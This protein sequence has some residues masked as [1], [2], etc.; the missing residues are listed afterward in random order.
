MS[1]SDYTDYTGTETDYTETTE[2]QDQTPDAPAEEP[3]TTGEE[4]DHAEKTNEEEEDVKPPPE[5]EV[6]PLEGL[7]YEDDP[8]AE[9]PPYGSMEYWEERYTADPEP[10]EWYQTPEVLLPHIHDLCDPEASMLI[11]GNGT[12]DLP[13]DIANEGFNAITV[14]DFSKTAIKK[15]RR[16]FK[17]VE[18]ITWKVGDVRELKYPAGEFQSV[19]DKGTLDC[20]FQLG[21][22][23]V[24][25]AM[26]EISRVLKKRGVFLCVSCFPQDF[27]R[28][29][30]NRQ[31]DLQLELE[32]VVELKKPLPSEQPHFLYI[33]RKTS[34]LLT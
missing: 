8:E 29:F 22:E 20:I 12:S 15:T 19:V 24:H 27:M 6:D 30:L 11:I 16:R 9:L 13:S 18:G 1:Q 7:T 21:D 5:P 34:K 4:E 25:N 28:P 26:A 14:I 32:T 10:F 31:A 2:T 17:E 3:E 23:E 33:V